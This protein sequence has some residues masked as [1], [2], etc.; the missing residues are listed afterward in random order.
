MTGG[1]THWSGAIAQDVQF[2]YL[3]EAA[4]GPRKYHPRMV[5][6]TTDSQV[7]RILKEE[8]RRCRSFTFSVA[9]VSPSALAMLKT[10]FLEF[11]GKGRIITSDY[12]AFNSPQAFSELMA[13]GKRG[14]D[15]RIHKASAFHP[16]GYIFE[17]DESVSAMVGSANLTAS[18]LVRNHEWN[19][20]VSSAKTGDLAVQLRDLIRRQIQESSPITQEWV[21]GYAASY[22]PPP[23]RPQPSLPAFSP[24]EPG[25]DGEPA[26][27]FER[28]D[29]EEWLQST[30]TGGASGSEV[31]SEGQPSN[32]RGATGGTS[33][34][35]EAPL[36]LPNRM[37]RHALREVEKLRRSGERRAIII[38]ATGTG[39]TILSAL[40]VKAANTSR[41]LFVVHR[42]QIVDKTIQEYQRVLGGAP[43]D[44]VK[45]SGSQRNASARYVFATVQTLA[46]PEVLGSFDASAF[47]YIVIDEAHRAAAAGHRRVI[48][49][50]TPKFLLGMTA[51]PE[52]MDGFNVFELF[53]FNVAYEIRLNEAL[54]AD[55]LAPFHYYGITD[56]TFDDGS[57]TSDLT[58]LRLLTSAARV[59]HVLKALETY[60]QAGVPP[61]GLIFASRLEEASALSDELNRRSLHG[62]PLR[63]VALTGSHSVHRREAAVRELE[64]GHLDYIVTVDVFNEG[65]DIPSVN[66]VV[67]LRQT[68]SA[69]VFVQQLGRG[70]RKSHG[71]DYLVV[72]DFIGN[73]ANNYMIPIA[74]FGDES[75][76]KESL[77]RNLIA[78]EE[79]GA[80]AGLSSVQFDRIAH[81]RVLS[82]VS[83]VKLD[84][85]RHLKSALQEMRNRVGRIP[86]LWDFV[87]F[88]SVDPV[89]LGTA[90]EN[91]PN[92]LSKALKVQWS[93]TPQQ[94]R[95]LT[96]LSGEVLTA[97]RPHDAALVQFLLQRTSATVNEIHDHL[98]AQGFPTTPRTA[99]SAVDTLTLAQ[100]AEADI[101]RYKMPLALDED[102]TVRLADHVVRG[103]ESNSEFRHAVDDLLK[104][105][106][107]I[108]AERFRG[109]RVFT[110]GRQYGRKEVARLLTWPRK[111]TPTIYGYRVDGPTS[112][113][114]IFVTLHKSEEISASTAYED[115]IVDQ[116]TMVWFT[117]SRRTLQSAE[118]A[119]IVANDVDI[120]VFVKKDDAEGTDFYYLG[121]ATASAAEQTTMPGKDGGPLPVVR[122]LLNFRHD[123]PSSLYDYFHPI[124]TRT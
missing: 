81:G 4:P 56:V 111:W 90:S 88:D 10:D 47:D 21:D 27:D 17:H 43:T 96:L 58:D 95:A 106:R 53:D 76:N 70:L 32:S 41:M 102:G 33:T 11:R 36:L 123:I 13:L 35:V 49:Y 19:L 30:S 115:A 25:L 69:I 18:A 108:V 44:Y 116:R 31:S 100:H 66:Q 98:S 112:V 101:N 63:T 38:S 72:I 23:Q 34:Q 122:M 103:Y 26:D 87:R 71:K 92:L 107:H 99:Q 118:V 40:C 119:S 105:A 75:L 15:V 2:G 8:I 6:N 54:E 89:V 62:R 20:L 7:L 78:A 55:M 120:H 5:L 93:L 121:Q 42:E 82:A 86:D 77:R 57:T 12:L 84:S 113:C 110:V 9:F 124:V 24:P 94:L 29:G 97:K 104:T 22:L 64:S 1:D 60:A 67:M 39:K 109:D 85:M 14:M 117:R 74:L 16:K 91:F 46:K 3:T 37:Q 28:I 50:F 59:D 114:P 51:T 73:Y 68:Q 65:V 48:D 83:A 61:R 45:L 52:R 80:I 79:R